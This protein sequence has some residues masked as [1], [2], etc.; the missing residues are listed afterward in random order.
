MEFV[1]ELTADGSYTFYSNAFGEHFHNREGAYREAQQTY[2][3]A[4]QLAQK[5]CQGRLCLLDICYGLGYNTAAALETIWQANPHCQ[6]VWVGLE[7]D[8][9]I[10]QA[11]IAQGLINRWSQPVQAS[12][13]ALAQ[14]QQIN[15]D[16]LQAQLLLGDARQQIY[17]LTQKPFQA[18]AIFLDPFSPPSCPQL[19]SLEFLQ[20]VAYC[21]KPD[22]R[23]ATYSAAA[24][25]RIAL[26]AAGLKL[27]ENPVAGRRWPGTL[28]SFH[29]IDLVP[30]CQ[31]AQEHLQT[32]AAVPYRDPHLTDTATVI[33]Q[34]R[35]HEQA[36]S[37]L[38][39]TT[40]WRKRWRSLL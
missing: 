35:R 32:R 18:D 34:R 24:A 15:S 17:L 33:Q 25:V 13:K 20:Q 7:L 27:G 16:R 28:A 30:L 26:L 3:E 14:Q 36:Q 11:A 38:E 21:L 19:W 22:G 40:R 9:A 12:L 6:V 29:A 10:P 4:T 31:Q 23:L 39:P 8:A 2:V 37:P 5:A 1:P